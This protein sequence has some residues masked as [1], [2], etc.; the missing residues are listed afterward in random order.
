L[1]LGSIQSMRER[2]LD[3][4]AIQAAFEAERAQE[5]STHRDLIRIEQGGTMELLPPAAAAAALAQALRQLSE[6][7]QALLN[8]QQAHRDLL[9]V[10]V[11]DNFNLKEEN[12]RLRKRLRQLEEE[13]GHLKESDWNHR[14]SL[15]ERLTELERKK[16]RWWDRLLDR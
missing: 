4:E 2:G 12:A 16:K 14:L 9:G 11:Q 7:Q 13:V 6:T 5:E 1:V 3:D 10:V 8:S 15:E